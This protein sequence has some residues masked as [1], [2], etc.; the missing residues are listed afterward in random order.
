MN[1]VIANA[2]WNNRGDEAAHRA[3]WGELRRLY[4]D[5][6]VR[7]L[8]KDRKSVEQFPDIPGFSA[9]PSQFKVPVWQI[10]LAVLSGGLLASDP[11]LRR[12][13]QVLESADLIIYSPGGSVINDRFFWSK[14][15]EYLLP[16]LCAR[17]YRIPMFVA[18][19]SMGPFD[20][21][22]RR[23]IR[24]WLLEAPFALCVREDIS[25][26]CLEGI[27]I[28]DNVHVTTDFA[29]LDF[30]DEEAEARR[31]AANT[32]LQAFLDAHEKV[33]GIT[34]TDFKW[35]V[36]LG[37][38]A[39]LAARIESAFREFIQWLV[40][41]GYGVLLLPQLFGNQNDVGVLQRCW[42][43]SACRRPSEGVR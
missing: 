8:V 26:G 9:E 33:V 27:G 37:K 28:R 16:F 14:Q 31:L 24:K 13:V 11:V 21:Q 3:L 5:A 40:Q 34:I 7:V 2:H 12:A 25:R 32:P 19:P 10:W 43:D 42:S 36:M 23:L 39:A 38:D 30:V 29:F 35:H 20:A 15:M 18:A 1:I 6:E 4:P 17:V 41:N 22:P